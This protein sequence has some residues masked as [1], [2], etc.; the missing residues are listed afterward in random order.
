MGG[1]LEREMG[2]QPNEMMDRH[3]AHIPEQQISFLDNVALPTFD[4]LSQLLPQTGAAY[5]EVELNR[6]RWQ[7]VKNE[8]GDKPIMVKVYMVVVT[9][10]SGGCRGTHCSFACHLTRRKTGHPTLG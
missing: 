3:R 5:E 8:V 7:M 6:R 1:D 10:Y 2:A 9:Y 4:L